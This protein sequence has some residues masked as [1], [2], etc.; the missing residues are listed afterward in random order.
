MIPQKR[1]R[2]WKDGSSEVQASSTKRH[3]SLANVVKEAMLAQLMQSFITK[4]EPMLR[5]VVREEVQR[6]L[7]LLD[8]QADLRSI[9][10]QIQ[11]SGASHLQLHFQ[12]RLPQSLFTGS[13]IEAED[14]CPIELVIVD[15]TTGE[16]VN[17]GPLSQI[18]VEI[19]ALDGD[20]VTEDNWSQHDFSRNVIREREG[21]RPLLT[22]DRVIPLRKGIGT[23]GQLV[24]TDNSSWIRSR[25]FRL[26]ARVGNNNFGERIREAKSEAFVV[27]DH[28]GELYKKHYPPMLKDEVW[29][30][31]KIGKEGC[32][33]TRLAAEKIHT[34]QDFLVL[35]FTDSARLR[36]VLGNGM[37]PKTWEATIR[38]A[39]TCALDDQLF[40]HF[41]GGQE[42]GLVFN[43]VRELVG[44][45]C[46]QQTYLLLT[47]EQIR[48]LERFKQIA[49]SNWQ[50]AMEIPGLLVEGTLGS[51]RGT[52]QDP[53]PQETILQNAGFIIRQDDPI[54]QLELV[55]STH[56]PAMTAPRDSSIGRNSFGMYEPHQVNDEWPMVES[57]YPLV[58]ISTMNV[59]LDDDPTVQMQS[60]LPIPPTWSPPQAYDLFRGHESGFVP[61]VTSHPTTS[62][63]M[64]KSSK[65]NVSWRK[66]KAA[67]KWGIPVVRELSVR[68]AA[69]IGRFSY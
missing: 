14:G 50:D 48:T 21:K 54:T 34:V 26:G 9:P 46:D 24:F 36:R 39:K 56:L 8:I 25:K 30:L 27:K 44:L 65:A 12:N 64:P 47:K 33:H 7:E 20:F 10:R 35:Y 32:F 23:V 17:S 18:K 49:Y 66:L 60:R 11:A 6:G 69:R 68:R 57:G 22:G 37:S 61:L 28:R 16:L 13:P 3:L 42:F 63:H 52:T 29:R 51:I 19:F 40:V 58:G 67:V 45:T 41:A 53:Q 43:S 38:H 62:F 1:P 55:H 31:E 15:S 4:I 2:E 59:G 5:K